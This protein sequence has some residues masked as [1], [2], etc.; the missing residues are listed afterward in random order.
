MWPSSGEEGLDV[1]RNV[2][3]A[4]KGERNDSCVYTGLVW[5]GGGGERG[6]RKRAGGG[7]RIGRRGGGNEEEED[8]ERGR[9]GG[10][11]GDYF[12]LYLGNGCSDDRG[13]NGT[14]PRLTVEKVVNHVSLHSS[15][16]LS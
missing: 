13:I 4:V 8:W 7:G 5:L 12:S 11:G 6:R 3:S 16:F 15:V 1:G 10:G 9:G 14:G 2:G